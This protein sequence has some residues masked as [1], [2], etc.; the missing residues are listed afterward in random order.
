MVLRKPLTT[1]L[2]RPLDLVV[3]VH[4]SRSSPTTTTTPVLKN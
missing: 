4:A 3:T 2:T 1:I